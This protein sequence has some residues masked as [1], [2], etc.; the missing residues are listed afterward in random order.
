MD[1]MSHDTVY[2]TVSR[3]VSWHYVAV[4]HSFF[5][6]GHKTQIRAIRLLKKTD[7]LYEKK[8]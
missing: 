5:L 7:F 4:W 1:D 6:Q 8:P 2:F 3:G